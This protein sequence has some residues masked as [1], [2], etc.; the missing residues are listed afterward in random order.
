[1]T[2]KELIERGYK[3]YPP[4]AIHS[5]GIEKCFQKRFDDKD[6]KKYFIDVNKWSPWTHP[7][8]NEVWGPNYEYETQLY[9]KGTHNAVNLTFHSSWN[10]E[11]VEKMVE[12]IFQNGMEHYERWDE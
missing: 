7:H 1:M 8:T 10:I 12:T 9:Q 4:T 2:D 3:E 5:R 6:G 11:D